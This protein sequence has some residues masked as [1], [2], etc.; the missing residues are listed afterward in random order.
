MSQI[1]IV[2]QVDNQSFQEF[3]DFWIFYGF[4]FSVKPTRKFY[5]L[6]MVKN[7]EK[8]LKSF[9][10]FSDKTF[11][12]LETK[13][14]RM[15]NNVL[16]ENQT[17]VFTRSNQGEA[18]AENQRHLG[19]CQVEARIREKFIIFSSAKVCTFSP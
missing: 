11:S 14:P 2:Q 7:E 17:R 8:L 1:H 6:V 9:Q 13:Q 18:G 10:I 3:S 19:F 12:R 15:F 4:Y 5:R 16:I